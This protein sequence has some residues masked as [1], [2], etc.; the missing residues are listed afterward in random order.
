M[1]RRSALALTAAALSGVG[2]AVRAQGPAPSQGVS[3]GGVM[4]RQA[5][6]MIDGQPRLLA[7]GASHGTVRVLTVGDDFVEIQIDGVRQRLRVGDRPIQMAR[8]GPRASGREI[9]LPAGRGGH[10]YAQGSINGKPIDFMVDTGAT[11]VALDHG[12]ALAMGIDLQNARASFSGTAN[13]M[14]RTRLVSLKSVRIH[15]VEVYDV[16]AVIVPMPMEHA[17]LGN[18]FLSRFTMLR[19]GDLM[20]LTRQ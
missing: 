7:A 3:L 16:E 17:L 5:M 15:D 12:R 4:G 20:R 19:Q 6:L 10:F 18:S 14:V 11:N 8:Q 1:R 13:G 9:V 2:G